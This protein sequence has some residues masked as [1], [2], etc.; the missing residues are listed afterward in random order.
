MK[1]YIRVSRREFMILAATSG[2]AKSRIMT[3]TPPQEGSRRSVN[4]DQAL[5]E[6]LDGNHRFM[7]GNWMTPRGRP[8]DFLVLRNWQFPEA[9]VVSCANSRVPPEI[10][11]D[12]GV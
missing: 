5:R 10:L 1:D 9:V 8:E 12:V 3:A 7:K 11:F 6:L 2:A 4:A